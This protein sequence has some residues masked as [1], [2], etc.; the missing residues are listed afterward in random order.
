MAEENEIG[1][2]RYY[3]DK[4]ERW[5]K[6]KDDIVKSFGKRYYEEH[7]KRFEALLRSAKGR[8]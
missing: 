1:G 7:L 6:G 4:I 3:T 8:V 5:K 2:V